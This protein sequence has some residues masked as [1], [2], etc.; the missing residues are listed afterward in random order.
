MNKT[1]QKLLQRC[2]SKL[3]PVAEIRQSNDKPLDKQAAF[4]DFARIAGQ[5]SLRTS[6]VKIKA[7][8]HAPKN[9]MNQLVRG[10]CTG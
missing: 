4:N 6:Q 3:H 8:A 5:T 9:L 10:G 1:S 2:L 7:P